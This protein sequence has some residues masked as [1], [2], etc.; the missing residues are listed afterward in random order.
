MRALQDEPA[1]IDA[2]PVAAA[3]EAWREASAALASA[4][5]RQG[6]LARERE[7]LQ[8]QIGELERLHPGDELEAETAV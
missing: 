6:E 7:R 8:W 5:T 1:G 2:R 4:R 3:F